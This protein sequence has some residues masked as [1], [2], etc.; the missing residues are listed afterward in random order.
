MPPVFDYYT[1]IHQRRAKLVHVE[2]MFKDSGAVFVTIKITVNICIYRNVRFFCRTWFVLGINLSRRSSLSMSCSS[3]T[4]HY[5]F[6]NTRVINYSY[7]LAAYK[8]SFI[9]GCVIRTSPEQILI[10]YTIHPLLYTHTMR[11]I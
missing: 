8:F 11:G 9:A 3:N 2:N 10:F 1:I 5:L 7:A 4:P 6:W